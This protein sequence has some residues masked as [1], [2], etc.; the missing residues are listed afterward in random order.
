MPGKCTG[1]PCRW[2]DVVTTRPL[3]KALGIA[4]H[5]TPPD[6]TDSNICRSIPHSLDLLHKYT[7]YP[8]TRRYGIRHVVLWVWPAHNCTEHMYPL[9][10][11]RTR[12][13]CTMPLDHTAKCSRPPT[14]LGFGT[15]CSC[16][17]ASH[18]QSMPPRDS[19]RDLKDLSKDSRTLR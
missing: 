2:T 1:S 4:L 13:A 12:C 11:W 6:K 17:Y 15:N 8:Y 14:H 10:M 9:L 3:S 5:C 7:S 16:C 19:V 18:L